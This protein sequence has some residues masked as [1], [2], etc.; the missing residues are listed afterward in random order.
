MKSRGALRSRPSTDKSEENSP[1]QR[2][3][4]AWRFLS[5]ESGCEWETNAAKPLPVSVTRVPPRLGPPSGLTDENSV[6]WT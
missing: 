1:P 3:R 5:G 4:A 2:Q 6:G